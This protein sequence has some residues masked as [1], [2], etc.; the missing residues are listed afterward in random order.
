MISKYLILFALLYRLSCA[1][2]YVTT[3][4]LPESLGNKFI[5]FGYGSNM[6]TKRIH[7]Q[8]PT[9]QKIGM[10]ILKDYRLDFNTFTERWGGAPATIV[11]T[12]GAY[13]YGTLWEIDLS[14][15]VDID[16]QEGVHEGIYYP[17]SLPVML[18]NNTLITARAYLLA[19]QPKTRLNDFSS[20]DKVPITRQPSITY[21]QCLV[22]GAEETG[23]VP[24]YVDWLKA[25]KHNGHVAPD[26]ERILELT[27]VKLNS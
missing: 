20:G 21:L 6:L 13:V 19:D 7:I 2:A 15:L 4:E 16:D 24:W 25:V 9:A 18:P 1:N 12:D 23:I 26:L 11:P 22:K 10:G 17:V 27:D 5:Y 8:N 3:T 14:N